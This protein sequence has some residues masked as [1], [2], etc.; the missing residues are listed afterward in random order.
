MQSFYSTSPAVI[1]VVELFTVIP[2][3]DEKAEDAPDQKPDEELA[4]DEAECKVEGGR[5]GDG[6]SDTPKHRTP[7]RP[8]EGFDKD[9][10]AEDR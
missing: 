2:A 10:S 7:N 8:E 3:C 4:K 6:S 9:Q 1:Q 5:P